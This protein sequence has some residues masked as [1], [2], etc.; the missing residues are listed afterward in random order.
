[1]PKSAQLVGLMTIALILFDSMI[2]YFT[3]QAFGVLVPVSAAAP[4]I[5]GGIVVKWGVRPII[6]PRYISIALGLSLVG[7]LIGMVSMDEVTIHRFSEIINS[8][9]VFFVGYYCFRWWSD[10]ATYARLF[11]L[12]GGAYVIVCLLALLKV[13]PSVF[14][15]INAIWSFEGRLEYRP[16]VMTDQN[17]QIFYLFPIVL[18][19]ALPYRFFRFGVAFLGTFGAVY[20]L[21]MLQTRSGFLILMVSILLCILAPIWTAHLGRQ[22]TFI[23][24]ILVFLIV[25]ANLDWIL[26]VGELLITRFTR[27]GMD[28]GY[29][30][31]LSTLYLF[32]HLLDPSWWIPRGYEEFKTLYRGTVPHSNITAMFLEGGIFGL[33]MWIVVFLLPLMSLMRMFFRRQL[34]PLATI[35]LLAGINSMAVQLSLNVPFFKQPWLWAGAVVGTLFRSRQRLGQLRRE[36][37]R[38][39]SVHSTSAVRQSL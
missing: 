31:V 17:F 36:S 8:L 29:G 9:S 5:V 28:T 6:P 26:N 27:T 21:A 7:F 23:L 37:L 1:M 4:F 38:R 32:E 30:R 20:V 14:P 34:D 24:P 2:T 39:R 35:V 19:L 25:V 18:V 10:E 22:K 13:A 12:V 16:E 33:Y 15:I 3:R 11:L